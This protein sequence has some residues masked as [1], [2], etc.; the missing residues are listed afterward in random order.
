MSKA[1][2]RFTVGSDAVVEG[3]EDGM[4]GM[5]LGG[6]RKIYVPSELGYGS[7]WIPEC[8]IPPGASLLFDVRL[9]GLS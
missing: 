5:K 4:L 6:E 1:P 7:E 3:F 2:L 9:I 8:R